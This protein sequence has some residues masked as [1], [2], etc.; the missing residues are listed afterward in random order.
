MTGQLRRCV[1]GGACIYPHSVTIDAYSF[2]FF[3]PGAKTDIS[4]TPFDTG[5]R[6]GARD[7]DQS[8]ARQKSIRLEKLGVC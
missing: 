5:T 7:V 2:L 4:A 8:N 6:Q 1:R 3:M